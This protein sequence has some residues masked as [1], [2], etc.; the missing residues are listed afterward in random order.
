LGPAIQSSTSLHTAWVTGASSIVCSAYRASCN[1][2]GKC[3]MGLHLGVQV[4]S[5]SVGQVRNGLA[6]GGE[7]SLKS[8][9][10]VPNGLAIGGKLESIA[11]V[12]SGLGLRAEESAMDWGRT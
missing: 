3:A 7:D 10:Q 12:P 8:V 1:P 6:S 2:L 11:R 5:Q 9:G 4:S